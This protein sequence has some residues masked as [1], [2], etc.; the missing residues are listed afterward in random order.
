VI[1]AIALSPA[2][3][4]TFTV[5]R[6]RP[7]TVHR[8]I[9]Y[10]MTA[11]GKGVNVARAAATLG[12]A[13][14]L[15]AVVH[16][17]SQFTDLFNSSESL[18][19]T[20][21]GNRVLLRLVASSLPT[22]TCLSVAEDGSAVMT[23]FNE[24]P[25]TLAPNEWRELVTEV[26]SVVAG[27]PSGWLTVSGSAPSGLPSDAFEQLVRISHASGWRIA[28]DTSGSA[29]SAALAAE[30]DL[31]KI[32]RAEAAE[33]VG[34]TTPPELIARLGHR[35]PS[36][37]FIVT[38]GVDGAFAPG[39]HVTTKSRGQ[40]P[41]GSGDAFLAGLVHALDTGADDL[42]ALRLAVGAGVANAQCIGA[43]RFDRRV[44]ES[45]AQAAMVR[46]IPSSH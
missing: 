11:G 42:T 7:G 3:D 46:V 27:G 30:P 29:L 5:E 15:A 17:P 6:L 18:S 14:T 16:Q 25:S 40:Y 12:A 34:Q 26:E 20:S 10:L 32:N 38:A 23:D 37:R 4:R 8:P 33:L 41:T 44:A 28:V 13:V 35:A 36:T 39:L 22:R 21:V 9:R 24:P 1:L 19:E 43:G 2:I 45:E 31:V